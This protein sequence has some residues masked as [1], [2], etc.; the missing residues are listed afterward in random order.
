MPHV[1]LVTCAYWWRMDANLP[2]GLDPD[3]RYE[4]VVCETGR[5][6]LRDPDHPERWLSTDRPAEVVR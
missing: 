1:P 6:E 4:F 3:G 5:L 2:R